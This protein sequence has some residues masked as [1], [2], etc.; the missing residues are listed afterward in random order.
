VTI[1]ASIS[2]IGETTVQRKS[3]DAM[4]KVEELQ[5]RERPLMP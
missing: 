2:D 5:C 4:T 1:L 3:F